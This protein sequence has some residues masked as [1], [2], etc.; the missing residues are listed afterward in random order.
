MNGF[1]ARHVKYFP[2]SSTT[3]MNVRT[4][5]DWLPVS[6]NCGN[7]WKMIR[8]LEGKRNFFT[9]QIFFLAA[10][11]LSWNEAVIRKAFEGSTSINREIF[12]CGL[13]WID[14]KCYSLTQNLHGNEFSVA[15]IVC[16][17]TNSSIIKQTSLKLQQIIILFSQTLI[18]LIWISFSALSQYSH[19]WP[20]SWFV[21][22]LSTKSEPPRAVNQNFYIPH[23]SVSQLKRTSLSLLY[24]PL[25]VLLLETNERKTLVK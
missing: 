21:A 12:R 15:I 13:G 3:G 7:E 25:L 18:Q 9:L 20:S 19:F 2:S 14:R 1:S 17:F 16:W 8:K 22:F 5:N 4:L 23:H 10:Q 6:E 11:S 24:E